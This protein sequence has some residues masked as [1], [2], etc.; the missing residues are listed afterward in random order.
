MHI[1][2]ENTWSLLAIHIANTIYWLS[3]NNQ[4]KKKI[5]SDK[6]WAKL[7]ASVRFCLYQSK[8]RSCLLSFQLQAL[9]GASVL[10]YILNLFKSIKSSL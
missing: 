9:I 10:F 2:I 1:G 5:P 4:K 7:W 8:V 6:K 3:V